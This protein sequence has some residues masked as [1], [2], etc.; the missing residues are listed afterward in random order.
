MSRHAAE[1]LRFRVFLTVAYQWS[2]EIGEE[3]EQPYI[4]SQM[5][6]YGYGGFGGVTLFENLAGT[7][8]PVGVTRKMAGW[9][10]QPRAHVR[11]NGTTSLFCCGAGS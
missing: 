7:L 3:D 10:G 5:S 1:M 6:A 8:S 4:L 2:M 11:Y 9:P